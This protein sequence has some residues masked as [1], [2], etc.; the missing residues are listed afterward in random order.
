[1][2]KSSHSTFFLEWLIV[3]CLAPGLARMQVPEAK[4]RQQNSTL[5]VECIKI[6]VGLPQ[7]V[8][9]PAPDIEDFTEIQLPGGR[10]RGFVAG[11][12]TYA[13]DGNRPWDMGGPARVVLD[14][15][16][17]GTYDDSGQWIH[18]VEQS[19]KTI[20]AFIHNESGDRPGQ[21]LQSMSLSVSADYG[22]TWKSYGQIITGKGA[23]LTL[24]KVTGT[25]DCTAIKQPDG[26][27]YAYC[28][29]NGTGHGDGATIM[30]RGPVSDPV[31]SKWKKYYQGKWDQ[32]GL[33]GEATGLEKGVGGSVAR[34]TANGEIL[35]LGHVPRGIGLQF[36]SDGINF[37]AMREPL[38]IEIPGSWHG[39]NPAEIMSYPVLYDPKT[40]SN[41]LPS[42]S[43]MMFYMFVQ[44]NEG[45]GRRYLVY[46]PVEVTF[47]NSPVSP[48]VGVL[49][50]RWYNLALHDRWST[51]QAVPPVNGSD[52]K[53][54]TKSGYLMTA[55]DPKQPTVEIEDCMSPPGQ[56][57][58]HMLMRKTSRGHVCEDHGYQRSR[59][60]GFV[61]TAPQ[62]RTQPLYSCYSESE[63]SHFAAN[64]EDCDR[65]GKQEALLGYDLKE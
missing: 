32:P 48:Q 42:G 11:G 2:K 35:L 51:T 44:P 58:V 49:L 41:Q 15:G 61:Y 36:S 1:M 31:P 62:P 38:L 27:Y 28:W 3:A 53:L 40:G 26:Y 10:F 7:V 64:S 4:N 54:E 17:R 21:G 30:A 45:L 23:V 34:L 20:L 60:A 22:L 33:G 63:K 47:S 6:R 59:T 55:A 65:L 16:A 46:R 52:Y 43:W 13:I 12:K 8:R 56:P 9:G 19:G 37:T 29:Q 18:H 57:L 5:C 39:R 25:A 50:A 14:R 24:H